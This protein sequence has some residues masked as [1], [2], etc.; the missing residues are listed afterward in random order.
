MQT[1]WLRAQKQMWSLWNLGRRYRDLFSPPINK[2][3]YWIVTRFAEA[4]FSDFL[5]FWS[6][7]LVDRRAGRQDSDRLI[8]ASRTA[9]SSG[10][11]R[12]PFGLSSLSLRWKRE[13]A[14]RAYWSE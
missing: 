4:E 10:F 5:E 8:S 6:W 13:P 2:L 1:T 14:A 3:F 7:G 9:G 12:K 11:S